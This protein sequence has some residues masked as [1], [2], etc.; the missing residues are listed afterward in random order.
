MSLSPTLI[1]APIH[2]VT[3]TVYRNAF[4]SCFGGFD[5][6]VTPFIALR[7]GQL[8]RP[9]ELLQVAPENNRSMKAVPQILTNHP[10]T[11]IAVL[12]QLRDAGHEEVNWN[13][14][15]PYPMVA[16]R[17]R[18]AGL[19]AEPARIDAILAEVL[20]DSPVKLSVKM[21]L[22]Y[23]SPDEYLAV[24]EVLNRYP[25]KEVILHARTA[26]QMYDGAVDN[27]RAGQMLA[28][29]HHPFVYNGDITRP[30]VFHDLCRQ[31]HGTTAWMI[32]RGALACPF[33]PA[34]LKGVPL[35]TQD[36][37]RQMLR[38]FHRNLM[39]G[40]GRR[41]SGPG[42]LKDKM[43]EQWKYLSLSFAN[44]GPLLAKVRRS[45][46]SRYTSTCEWAFDQPL[47]SIDE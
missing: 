38:E 7:Q 21:R 23:H 15:C 2:G 3:D 22:G 17:G 13:L 26:D 20:N 45:Y 37:R 11:F 16:G 1:L 8:S 9:A 24:V 41:L 43:L 18:G 14:G 12:R 32:G 4:A 25:L 5:R 29:C 10:Q 28:S 27:V 31:L 40:Y 34:Q 30:N 33:L 6:A 35:P 46:T 44:P 19:L 36:A 47:A 42:H 39:E